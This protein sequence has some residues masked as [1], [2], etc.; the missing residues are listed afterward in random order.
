MRRPE[1]SGKTDGFKRLNNSKD[2]CPGDCPFTWRLLANG[3]G[4]D[5]SEITVVF[6]DATSLPG[7]G[8]REDC[9]GHPARRALFPVHLS[10]AEAAEL[11]S[12][13]KEMAHIEAN[14]PE[15]NDEQGV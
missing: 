14:G 5:V 7:D 10:R 13:I 15:A 6:E 8:D 3:V 1:H 12:V 2:A 4:S 11:W 9:C